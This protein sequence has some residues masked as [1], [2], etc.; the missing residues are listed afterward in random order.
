MGKPDLKPCPRQCTV[1]PNAKTVCEVMH[2]WNKK[3]GCETVRKVLRKAKLNGRVAR[4]NPF[5]SKVNKNKRLHF[6]CQ[7]CV[8]PP[9]YWEDIIFADKSKCNVFV[10]DGRHGLERT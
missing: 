10:S 5:V 8:K 6:A 3:V 2:E 4:K 1:W 7:Y 9:E